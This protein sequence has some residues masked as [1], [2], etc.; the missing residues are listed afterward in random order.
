MTTQQQPL[1]CRADLNYVDLSFAE[2]VI[3]NVAIR[4]GRQI[5]A[6]SW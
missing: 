5:I 3:V 6:G 2:P 4:D 1:F